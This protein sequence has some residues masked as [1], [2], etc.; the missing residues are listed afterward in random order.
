MTGSWATSAIELV[1]T[2]CAA[3]VERGVAWLDQHAPG[4]ADTDRSFDELRSVAVAVGC[5][6]P[7]LEE[8]GLAGPPITAALLG[9]RP[10]GYIGTA[11]HVRNVLARRWA[12]QIASRRAAVFGEEPLPGWGDRLGVAP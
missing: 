12:E 5:D 10:R 11:E 1:E 4:W 8:L 3:S 9:G 7:L 6:G 2:D